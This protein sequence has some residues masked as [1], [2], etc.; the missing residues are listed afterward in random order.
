MKKKIK[1]LK[2]KSTTLSYNVPL[3]SLL[4]DLWNL[5]QLICESAPGWHFLSRFFFNQQLQ[6][7]AKQ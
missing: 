1:Y 4:E 6:P 5:L 7:V 3:E 2:K